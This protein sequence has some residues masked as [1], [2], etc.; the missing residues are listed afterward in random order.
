MGNLCNKNQTHNNLEQ[1]IN[2]L[3]IEEIEK[4]IIKLRYI[5]ELDDLKAG[6][7]SSFYT[8]LHLKCR[9]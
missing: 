6:S 8:F 2:E 9:F 1:I 5:N 4:D 7:K 3:D